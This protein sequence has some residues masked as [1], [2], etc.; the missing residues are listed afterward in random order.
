VG[1]AAHIVV[2]AVEEEEEEEEEEEKEEE[3]GEKE[4]P[5]PLP[6][7]GP[8]QWPQLTVSPSGHWRR[9]NA[10]TGLLVFTARLFT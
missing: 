2:E 3:R 10:T 7:S 4:S 8:P 9:P 6:P 1:A 5:G